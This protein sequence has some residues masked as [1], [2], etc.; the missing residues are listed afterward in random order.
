MIGVVILTYDRLDYA[1]RALLSLSN[2]KIPESEGPLWCHIADDGS[3]QTYRDKLLKLA[4]AEFG[5]N[6]SI[7]NSERGGYGASYNLATQIVHNVA[8]LILPLEDDWELIRPL[9]LT[10][11][12]EV[13]RDGTFGCVRLGYVGYTQELVASFVAAHGY[14]WLALHADSSEP[15]VFAGGP[16]LE[17]V[18]WERSVGPWPEGLTA[19]ETEFV[20]AHKPEARIGVGWPVD[21]VKPAGD[22]FVHIGTNHASSEGLRSAVMA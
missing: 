3:S 10:P 11:I 5:D 18:H 19:G 8:D 1:R 14:H 4:R 7:T 21:L 20:V 16:R 12:V 17:T 2:L 22:A 9:D 6:V 15:H 13:L